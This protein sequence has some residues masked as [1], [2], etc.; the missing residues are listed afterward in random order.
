MVTFICKGCKEEFKII[1]KNQK[2]CTTHCY[3]T[4]RAKNGDPNVYRYFLSYQYWAKKRNL[5]FELTLDDFAKLIVSNCFYCGVE[6]AIYLPHKKKSSALPE[7]R[8]GVDRANSSEG[9]NKENC[10]SC[11]KVC[12][13][14]KN[15]LPLVEFQS[16][17]RQLV[18][19]RLLLAPQLLHT[20]AN[21]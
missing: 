12:N 16:W 10:V 14:A 13:F 18:Q 20:N 17:L 1:R 6:P 4:Y 19:Y 5:I 21:K 15:N 2:Y 11:C 8:N 3:H 9:Y 7:K